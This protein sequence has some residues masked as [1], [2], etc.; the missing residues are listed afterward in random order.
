MRIDIIN[1]K[2]FVNIFNNTYGNLKINTI[3]GLSIDSRKIKKGDIYFPIHGDFYDGHDFINK[4]FKNGA[5]ISF[6]EKKSTNKKI[7]Y[8]NSVKGEINKLCKMWRKLS[9]AKI[10]GITGSNGKTTTKNILYHI[11]INKFKCSKTIGNYNSSIGLPMTYLATS[12]CDDYCIIEYG[13]SMPNEIKKLCEILG[14]DYSFITNISTAHI[15]NYKSIDEIYKTKLAI[16]QY[17]SQ[18]GISF[19]NENNI[20][21]KKQKIKSQII[22]FNS[23]RNK[24]KRKLLIPD[25]LKHIKELIISSNIICKTLGINNQ[26]INKAI[27][28]FELPKGRGNILEYMD[29]TIIDDS[30]NANPKSMEFAIKRLNEMSTKGKKIIVIGDMLELG[31]HQIK[32]HENLSKAINNSNIDIILTFG[33]LIQTTFKK[34]TNEKYSKHY[35]NITKLKIDLNNLASKNDLIYLKGSRSMKLERTYE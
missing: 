28:S 8:T 25:H 2:E 6:S 14:P 32:E 16:Y 26:T 27:T 13:A 33:K 17:T 4:S 22:R 12:L 9:K 10:L 31:K 11:L 29:Y 19:I 15:E 34:I 35:N 7:I 23:S 20:N 18:N 5:I 24:E 21:I 1:K 30:Y 3:N